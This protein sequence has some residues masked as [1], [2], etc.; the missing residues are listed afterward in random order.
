MCVCPICFNNEES[1]GHALCG[2]LAAQD[3]WSQ[4]CMKIQKVSF[5]SSSF[6]DMWIMLTNKL[7]LKDL[8]E[9]VVI[10]KLTWAQRN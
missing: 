1:V 7:S 6:L 4:A 2:C 5:S 3:V 10:V 9:A 8:S